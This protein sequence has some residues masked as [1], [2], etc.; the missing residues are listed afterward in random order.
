MQREAYYDNLKYVLITL[1]VVGHFALTYLHGAGSKPVTIFKDW[2]WL[3]H[4]PAFLFVSGMFAKGLYKPERG[5]KVNSI[6]FYLVMY[7]LF[8]CFIT[9]IMAI[10]EDP[11]FDPFI[12]Y[13][14]PWYFLALAVLGA[15]TPLI[16]QLKPGWKLVIPFSIGISVAA[17][18]S[19]GFTSFLS[20]GRIINFAPF[21]FAGYFLDRDFFKTCIKKVRSNPVLLG[22]C[23][24]FLVAVFEVLWHAPKEYVAVANNLSM[25]YSSYEGCGELPLY[26]IAIM[27]LLWFPLAGAM[28]FAVAA[29]VPMGKTFFTELGQR[30]LQVYILHPLL[31][32]PIRGL[33][34]IPNYVAPYIVHDGIFTL[35]AAVVLTFVIAY[36]K[37]PARLLDKLHRSIRLDRNDA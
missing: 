28:T 32:L 31:Y 15:L 1:V 26:V 22:A 9:A 36:P 6:C 3:F 4:M 2:I 12:V 29:L 35:I 7:F 27:R 37:F 24:L 17:G 14:I 11:S 30:T 20:M 25:A 34:I 18:F 19:T 33:D 23:I 8:Y 10:Y 13:R 5:L 16:Y 21:Y